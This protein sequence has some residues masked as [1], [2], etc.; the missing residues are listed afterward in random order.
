MI[1]LF[2]SVEAATYDFREQILACLCVFRFNSAVLSATDELDTGCE[3][4]GFT[5]G[6]QH[7]EFRDVRLAVLGARKRWCP[8]RSALASLGGDVG[9]SVTGQ[10]LRNLHRG[11]WKACFTL[12][13][14]I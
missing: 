11:G 4:N 9:N 13:S 14:S 8:A 2:Q 3:V 6:T 10:Q 1:Y 7:T 12:R 5:A